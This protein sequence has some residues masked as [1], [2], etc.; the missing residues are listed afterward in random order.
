MS[1]GIV[2]FVSVYIPILLY[3]D[4]ARYINLEGGGVVVVFFSRVR[5]RAE[6]WCFPLC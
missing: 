3:Q 4:R 1:L 2:V 5:S 6:L